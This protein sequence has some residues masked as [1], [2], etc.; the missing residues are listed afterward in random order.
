ML[1]GWGIAGLI[2]GRLMLWDFAKLASKHQSGV[3]FGIHLKR[4]SVVAIVLGALLGQLP[5]YSKSPSVAGMTLQSTV[6]L[7]IISA[8]VALVATVASMRLIP[9]IM[10]LIERT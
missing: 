2:L 3:A 5:L 8:V 7:T 6:W 4:M 10:R 9:R 1:T